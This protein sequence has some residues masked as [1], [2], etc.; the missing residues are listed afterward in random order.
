VAIVNAESSATSR[1]DERGSLPLV[2]VVVPTHRRPELLA[3][4]V[5]SIARQD[6]AGPI[7]CLL[8]F[9]RE[10]PVPPP[11]ELPPDVRSSC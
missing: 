3:R 4:A 8:V 5:T 6:Y 2:S 10:D 9:D 1:N 11:V 7:E